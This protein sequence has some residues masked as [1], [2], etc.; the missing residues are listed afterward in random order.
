M[1]ISII[2]TRTVPTVKVDDD[3]NS[4]IFHSKYDPLREANAWCKYALESLNDDEKV[5][6]VGLGAGYHIKKLAETI[7]EKKITV[8]EF[9]SDYYHWFMESPLFAEIKVYSNVVL[10]LFSNL[11][12]NQQKEVFTTISLE[13]LCI[14]K[15]GLD[16][17]PSHYEKVKE[18]VEDIQFRKNSIKNQIGNIRGNFAKNIALRDEGIGSLGNTY[19]GKPMILISAG[20]SLDKQMN[21]L[22]QIYNEDKVILGAVATAIKPLLKNGIIPHFFIL[23]DPNITTYT[24]L[25][26]INLPE[27]PMFYLSS[28][29]HD[30]VLLHK[31]PRRILWQNGLTEA[32]EMAHKLNEPLVQTG[33]SVATALLDLMIILGASN[34]ALVGQDLA[35]TD[36]L[37]HASHAHAQKSITET[38]VIH[39]T[40][41]YYQNG[42]VAT[43]KN[44]TI[45]RK[46]FE[47]YAEAHPSLE[48]YNCTEGGAYINNWKHISLNSYYETIR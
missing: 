22:K 42:E 45:Y 37:S 15:S 31:G 21:L 38:A 13:N 10:K 4:I 24:Q 16:M 35:Y 44:L 41:N 6:I 28:A 11:P 23:I 48:L 32:E 12:L 33:G 8:I 36:G 30:T 18:I 34:V 25:T 40:M 3:K 27:T 20:P 9:N 26:D 1:N 43:A 5:V 29:F 7:P 39:W 19:Q 17:M 46:W 14:H 47:N 2:E